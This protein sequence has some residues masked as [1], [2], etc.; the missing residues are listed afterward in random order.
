MNVQSWPARIMSKLF[1]VDYCAYGF[2]YMKPTHLW[3]TL[4]RWLPK[5]LTGTGTCM[6]CCPAGGWC[7][8][9]DGRRSYV[10]NIGLARDPKIGIRGDGS[11]KQ[12]N[13]IP[14][15]LH[16][17]CLVEALANRQDE[18]QQVVL[19]LCAGYGSLKEVTAQMHL[20]YVAVGIL[21]RITQKK[22]S[23]RERRGLL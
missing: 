9:E 1:R 23:D 12:L 7:T 21:D 18:C 11:N 3:S 15:M 16:R 17:E 8:A 2:E 6:K 14:P 19:D 13:A 5:G 10:H 4:L 20:K 22:P